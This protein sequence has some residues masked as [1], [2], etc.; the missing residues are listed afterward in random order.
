[1]AWW[2]TGR[3]S[4]FNKVGAFPPQKAWPVRTVVGEIFADGF[5][6]GDTSAWS[7]ESP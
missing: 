1:V 5:E 4:G 2:G 3:I 6:S 7:A